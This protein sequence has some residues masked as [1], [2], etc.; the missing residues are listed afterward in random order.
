MLK[1]FNF[2]AL[3][4]PLMSL[5]VASILFATSGSWTANA[6]PTRDDS[7]VQPSRGQE[8]PVNSVPASG[9]SDNPAN[10]SPDRRQDDNRVYISDIYP[11][12]CRSYFFRRDWISLQ[13]YHAGMYRCLYGV[14]RN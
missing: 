2:Q 14:D 12:Y 11:E 9:P 10:T 4:S 13:E 3:Q 7:T 6:N 1:L 8:Q 5:L